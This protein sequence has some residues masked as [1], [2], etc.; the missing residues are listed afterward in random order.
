MKILGEHPATELPCQPSLDF[1]M[2]WYSCSMHVWMCASCWGSCVCAHAPVYTCVEPSNWCLFSSSIFPAHVC[3]K[4]LSA[5]PTALVSLASQ[6]ALGAPSPPPKHGDYRWVP[7][8][9]S[10]TWGWDLNSGPHTSVLG[11]QTH[12]LSPYFMFY[13]ETRVS[14]FSQDGLELML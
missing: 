10:I 11:P 5:G 3:W 8:L 9:L 12:L 4:I 7:C 6:F 2:A 13:F 1:F 14:R